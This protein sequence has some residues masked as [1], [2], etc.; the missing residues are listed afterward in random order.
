MIDLS[1]LEA[2]WVVV[3]SDGIDEPERLMC[4]TTNAADALRA[5]AGYQDGSL[6]DERRRPIGADGGMYSGTTYEVRG[7]IRRWPDFGQRVDER[8]RRK[9]V[10]P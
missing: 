4:F 5:L 6:P 10:E 8:E 7:P 2:V 3:A 9:L 1:S